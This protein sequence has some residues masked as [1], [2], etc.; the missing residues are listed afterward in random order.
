MTLSK[1]LVLIVE[2]LFAGLAVSVIQFPLRKTKRKIIYLF[3]FLL[4][5]VLLTG[6]A[7]ELIADASPFVWKYDFPISALYLAIL[8]DLVADILYLPSSFLFHKKGFRVKS[9]LMMIMLVVISSYSIINM[10]VVSANRHEI[11]SDKLKNDYKFVF[12]SDLHYGS[13]QS[14]V[15]VDRTLQKIKAEDPDFILL[16]GDITD[17]H[18]YPDEAEY[19][20]EQIAKIGVPVY[21]VYGNHDRQERGDYLGGKRIS[22]EQLE[23]AIRNNGIHILYESLEKINEDLLLLGR[24]DPSHPEERKA[25]KDLPEWPKDRYVICIDHTPYQ[26]KEIE[27]IGA[28][29]QLSGHT[30]AGQLFPLKTLYALAGLNVVGNY[31]I[32]NCDLYVSPGVAG[33]YLPLRNESHC[34]YEVFELTAP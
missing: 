10:Q 25:V 13:S 28:D 16:G 31:Q 33:W 24:E 9:I 15:T 6:I 11:V 3:L 29:L 34:Y 20:Y 23:D 14:K 21:F 7:Y 17:E 27:E 12:I 32:G 26:N 18:T 2:I 4:K 30:H 5:F 22:E 19:L 8:A 1:Y